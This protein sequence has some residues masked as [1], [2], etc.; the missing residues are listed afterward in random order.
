MLTTTALEQTWDEISA[1]PYSDVVKQILR[2]RDKCAFHWDRA[3]AAAFLEREATNPERTPFIECEDDSG[4]FEKIR[5]PWALEAIA[6]EL[7]GSVD[8]ETA[9]ARLAPAIQLVFRTIV[10]ADSLI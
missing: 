3:I 4:R 8:P 6:L 2:I 5:F 9:R 7:G 1:N 10:L